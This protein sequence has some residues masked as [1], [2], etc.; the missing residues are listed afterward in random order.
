MGQAIPLRCNVHKSPMQQVSRSISILFLCI[1]SAN[2][3]RMLFSKSETEILWIFQIMWFS[4]VVKQWINCVRFFCYRKIRRWGATAI[5]LRNDR[6]EIGCVE[7]WLSDY[8]RWN[9]DR[10]GSNPGLHC[11]KNHY[12]EIFIMFI[13]FWCFFGWVR[14]EKGE[15]LVLMFSMCPSQ[16][17]LA[18]LN[19]LLVKSL[20]VT[21]LPFTSETQ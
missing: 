18:M 5:C 4:Y 3:E 12:Q 8:R 21:V 1:I 17:W 2:F 6:R 16:N 7:S 13:N 9:I 15:K 20:T 10:F 11:L 19:Y 14:V